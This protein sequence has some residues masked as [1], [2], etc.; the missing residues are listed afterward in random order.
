MSKPTEAPKAIVEGA[1]RLSE[2]SL[3][4]LQR[5]YYET[6]GPEAWSSAT[7][8]HYITSNPY[9]ASAFAD[10]ILAFQRDVGEPITVVE[11]GA[12]S[13]R[14]SYLLTDFRQQL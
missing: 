6:A 2:S 8:P 1:R 12:G 7:V 3:W 11:L 14:F 5:R 9:I 10:V 4:R 13:G